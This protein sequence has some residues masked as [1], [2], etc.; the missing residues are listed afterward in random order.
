M[1]IQKLATNLAQAMFD[2]QTATYTPS[3]TN[4]QGAAE[5]FASGTNPTYTAAPGTAVTLIPSTDSSG[6]LVV[7]G[8]KGQAGVEVITG[9]YTNPDGTVADPVTLTFTQSVDPAEAD[10]QSFGGTI[11]TPVAQGPA[12]AKK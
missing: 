6:K 1:P 4:G 5:A 10:V 12:T 11:S 8:I 7:N 3:P 9:T 2:D